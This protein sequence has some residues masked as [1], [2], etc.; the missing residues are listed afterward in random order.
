MLHKKYKIKSK[1]RFT[2]FLT[3]IILLSTF[4]TTGILGYNEAKS[5]TKTYYYEVEIQ[6]GDTLWQLAETY[7]DNGKDTRENIY[8][9]CELNNIEANQLIIGSNILIPDISNSI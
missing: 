8:D 1:F 3:L 7:M 5:L 2:L 4:I 6:S 9:L